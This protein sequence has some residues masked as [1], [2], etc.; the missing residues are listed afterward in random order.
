MIET[1][2]FELNGKPEQLILETDMILLWVLRTN[3]GL[4]G[5]KFGCGIGF[6]GACTVIVDGSPVRS[7]MVPVSDVNGKK[8]LTIEGL[9]KNGSLHP[10]QKAF[11]AHDAL[12]CGYCTPGMIMNAYG[13]LLRNP[14]PSRQDI[15]NGMEENLCR[16][17]SYGRIIT[18][19][20]AAAVEMKGGVLI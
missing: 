15:I 9:S 12:Q 10:L 11:A 20:Q 7:C 16:C 3:F 13:L 4:T 8:V 6:C 19:I 18:A 5:T 17:G 1:I 14:E 2:K